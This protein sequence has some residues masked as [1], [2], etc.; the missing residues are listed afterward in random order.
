MP[1]YRGTAPLKA[2]RGDMQPVNVYR[3][4]TKVAGW[5]IDTQAGT[6]PLTLANTYNDTADV[7]L[8]GN[9]VQGTPT[10][11]DPVPVTPVTGT[12]N[13]T[14]SDGSGREHSEAIPLGTNAM[15]VLADGTADTIEITDAKEIKLTKR[16]GYAKP[17]L[18]DVGVF[19]IKHSAGLLDF[20]VVNA[21]GVLWVFPDDTTSTAARPAR[22][23]A[24]GTTYLTVDNW[25]AANL[26]LL[27]NGTDTLWTGTLAD[28]PRVTSYLSIKGCSLVT[29]TLADL[30]RV[31][32][33]LSMWGCSLVTGTLADLPRVTSHLDIGGCS[34]V[35]GTL[36]D[37]P[38]VTSY[39]SMW[40]CSLVTGTLADLPRVTS[41]L[42]MWGCSLVTGALADP[43]PTLATIFLHKTAMSSTDT[44]NTL[45]NLAAHT[46]VK[47]GGIL[48]IRKNRTPAS[49]A[50]FAYL[51]SRF[52][53]TEV[54]G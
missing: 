12:F 21:T 7:T 6:G 11:D 45:I 52:A 38:R 46:A 3:G 35:T 27:D 17:S 19:A 22:S 53:I 15:A 33:V 24:K 37:L 9:V 31:T 44:D 51:S 13:L 48:Q 25:Q 10:P 4:S 42:S 40:G 16:L 20:S 30:P 23:V 2:Y 47:S 39:L 36:A 41:V 49:D 26:Q 32:S 54:V 43:A 34:L 8:A 1:I 28:L 5:H 29:G 14:A 18:V 50:A